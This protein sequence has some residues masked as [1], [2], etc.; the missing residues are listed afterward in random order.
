MDLVNIWYKSI[1]FVRRGWIG[2]ELRSDASL[3]SI[4][5]S[6]NMTVGFSI[7]GSEW[8]LSLTSGFESNTG[9]TCC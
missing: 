6:I 4:I 8:P 1:Y 2:D 3:L 7:K 9:W 5:W